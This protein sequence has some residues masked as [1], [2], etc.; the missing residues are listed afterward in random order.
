MTKPTIL[1]TQCLQNDFVAPVANG[2]ALPNLLHIGHDESRRLLGDDVNEGPISQLVNWVNSLPESSIEFVHIRDWHDPDDPAQRSHLSQFG[3]HCIAH[4][5]GA[6]FV[7]K[8]QSGSNVHVIN[9]TSLNDFENTGLANL[10]SG[11]HSGA[12]EQ[13]TIRVGIIGVWTEA[14]VL[15]LAYEL[16]TRYPDFEIA[17][18]S[19]LTASSSRSQHFFALEQLKRIV[20][21][22][23]IDSLGEFIEYLG[24]SVEQAIPQSLS[25]SLRIKGGGN[26]PLIRDDEKLLRYLYRDCIAIELKI[27][28]GGFSGNLVAGV[29][30][31]D[32]QGHEQAPHVVKIGERAE[33]ARERTAFEQIE[34]V[35]GN[36][37]PAVADYADL[38]QRG[39]IKYRYASMGTGKTT[40]FQSLYMNGLSSEQ[41]EAYLR[42][43]YQTQLGRFYRAAIDDNQ[44]LLEYYC[45]DSRWADSVREKILELI[46]C[47]PEKGDLSLPANQTCPNLYQFYKDELDQLPPM[48]ADFPFSFVHGDLNGANIIIDEREN[49]WLIDFFHTHRGHVLKDFSKLENDLLY[50][51]TPIENEGD[52]A[53]AYQFT[54]FLLSLEQPLVVDK[55]LPD[56]FLTTPFERTFETLKIIRRMAKQH[57]REDSPMQKM[58]WLIPQLRYAVHTIGFDE[59]NERQRIWALYGAATISRILKP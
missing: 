6:D 48:V 13:Q 41:V 38:S 23:V 59:P 28:D 53:L 50:I 56:Q 27:L 36:N 52:L 7:F 31:V 34:T 9:S 51:Y 11:F 29:N 10:L 57:I 24:G 39:A 15:F 30:S 37:A 58:Q 54:D 12:T 19:A 43:V 25:D 46:P 45:F 55:P 49:V 47:C 21:V 5:P 26:A 8:H 1:I 35:M 3:Q 22:R 4:T 33:M 44:N 20:G 2:D 32:M 17:V 18:C 14:K 16:S 42:D 40:T